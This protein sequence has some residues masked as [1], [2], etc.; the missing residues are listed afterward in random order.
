MPVQTKTIGEPKIALVTGASRGIGRRIV[1]NL[2][3]KGHDVIFT[4]R[5]RKDEA[6]AVVRE[7]A[8]EGRKAAMLQLNTADTSHFP[9]FIEQVR[10]VLRDVWSRERID[11]LVNNA[12]VGVSGNFADT[13]EAVFDAMMNIHLK[14]VYFLT[15]AALPLIADG[16]RI[17]NTST[18]LT[19]FTAPT[20]SAYAAMKGGVEVLTRYLALE[21][22]PR[23]ITVN[24]VAPGPIATD[25]A[26]GVIRDNPA[27]N[28]AM[29]NATALGRAGE[30]DDIGAMIASLLS[31]DNRWINGQRIEVSGGI[32]L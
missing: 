11:W 13:S 10:G 14:G 1:M 28:T 23:R 25:F 3:A 29:A 24:C 7:V 27:Y 20:W 22:G 9:N 5:E 16:G 2:A 4:Y 17:V 30:P 6:E 19:R 21:L 32:Y 18:G 8:A 26:G 15:Q 12:G 31:D